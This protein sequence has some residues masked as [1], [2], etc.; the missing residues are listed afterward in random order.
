M[1]IIGGGIS[2]VATAYLCDESWSVDLF[3]AEARL[4]GNAATVDV[5]GIPV[6]LG[7]ETFNPSTHPLY[8]ELLTRI[9]VD[10]TIIELPGTL[11]VSDAATRRPRFVSRHPLRTPRHALGLLQFIRA[12]RR[13]IASDPSP[14][15]TLE[16]WFAQ[17]RFAPR[18]EREVLLPWLA[19]LTSSRVD[20]LKTQSMLAFL[21]LF[22]PAFPANLLSSPKTYGSS[23]GLGGIIELLAAGCRHLTV[24]TGERVGRAERIDGA[25]FIHTPT[26][27]S[28]PYEKLV[29]TAPPYA[30]REFLTGIP[31]ALAG[32]LNRYDYYPA[33]LVIHGDPRVM[34]ADERDWCM[35]N[36][37]ASGETCEASFW[38]GA[39]R[40]DPV[41]GAPVRLFKSW[42]THRSV[43]PESV[44]A[45]RT[46]HHLLLTPDAVRAASDLTE[47]QG[48]DGLFFA[49]H[50]TQVTDLQETALASAI[51]VAEALDAGS[52]NL[53]ALRMRCWV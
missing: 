20:T 38:L 42:A 18:F 25:W 4:G 32:I 45:E 21:V 30:A 27:R 39:S 5:D 46:F 43:A 19:S 15:L 52:P 28:G 51:A 10:D 24:R 11:S 47:W 44:R 40:T 26:G 16:D 23:I 3:E 50:F 48:R 13:F 53:R 8:W 31:D 22:A 2:G 14:D 1:A 29:V 7:A 9:G 6:D 37:A 35:H 17:Q 12:A 36:A 41:T 33:R 49:G 34:P